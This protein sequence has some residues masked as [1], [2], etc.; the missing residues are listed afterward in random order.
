MKCVITP[1]STAHEFYIPY[2]EGKQKEEEEEKSM[3][4]RGG[5]GEEGGGRKSYTITEFN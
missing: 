2:P 4:M 5:D 3:E 1:Y